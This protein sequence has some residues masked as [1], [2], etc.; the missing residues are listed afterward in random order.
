M[1]LTPLEERSV[2]PFYLNMMGTNA[3]RNATD[4]WPDLLRAGEDVTLADASW[5][6]SSGD[7]NWRPVVMGAW[8]SLKF[9]EHEIGEPL[10]RAMAESRGSLTAPPLAV[11]CVVLL[12]RGATDALASYPDPPDASGSFV[13]AARES[14]DGGQAEES[15]AEDRTAFAEM[16]AIGTSLRDAWR[17]TR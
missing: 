9:D 13:A 11:A 10:R 5:L 6:I 14:V 17:P 8:F 2:L 15:T 1:S 4:L 12:G 16:R 7:R 3:R